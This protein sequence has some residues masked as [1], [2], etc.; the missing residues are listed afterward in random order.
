MPVFFNGKLLTTPTV[1]TRIDD[2]AMANKNLTVA[3]NLAII[4]KADSGIPQTVVRIGSPL[5]A[6]EIFATGELVTAIEK[7]FAPSAETGAPQYIHALRVQ[8]ATQSHLV[9]GEDGGTPITD[10]VV[11]SVDN[12]N[13]QIVL[14]LDEATPVNGAYDGYLITM[15]SGNAIGETNLITTFVRESDLGTCDVRYAWENVPSAG[16]TLSIVPCS[17]CLDSTDYGINTNRI[18]VKIEAGTVSGKCVTVAFDGT[19]Y[20]KDNLAATYFTAHYSGGGTA[21]VLKISATQIV[22]EETDGGTNILGTCDFTVH[23]TV[24]KVV[25]FLNSITNITAEA[26]SDYTDY[27]VAAKLDYNSA[28]LDIKTGTTT[29]VTANLQAIVDWI[30][31]ISEPLIDVYRP[32]EA[33]KAPANCVFSY[34]QGGTTTT[35]TNTDW[36]ACFDALQTEDVQCV[37]PLSNSASIHAMALTHCQYMSDTAGMERRTIVGGATGETVAELV[38]RAKALNHDRVYLVAPAYQ[39]YDNVGVLTSYA[40]YMAAAML[41]G[42]ITGSDPGT[43]L[44]N[45]SVS[46]AGFLQSFRIPADTDVLIEGGVIAMADIRGIYKVVQSVSTWLTNGNYNRVE[47]ATGFAVDFVTRNVRNALQVLIGQKGTPTI[48]GRAVSITENALKELA[49]PAPLGPEVITG[50]DANPAYKNI[51]AELE[52]DVLRVYFQCSPVVPVNYIP[53]GIAI[54]PYSGTASI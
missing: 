10:Y 8:P 28:G 30:A 5:E 33:G 25:D 4:G 41:G 47:M 16:D 9:V 18:K 40:P 27:P 26:V 44:T 37:V 29:N 21:C 53:V 17:F 6:R 52:G 31:G 42:M 35:P 38:A 20:V 50:D 24:S 49:R 51:T 2:S 14:D 7:A 13:K 11:D 32:T 22:V 19:E 46:V 36:Q 15:T 54:V 34:L 39:A 48:L 3:N 43:S 45:K 12:A 1:A 23:D